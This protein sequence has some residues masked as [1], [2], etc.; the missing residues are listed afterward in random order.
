MRRT[1]ITCTVST[2]TAS[3]APLLALF[4]NSQVIVTY[5][6]CSNSGT[7]M[8]IFELVERA[9]DGSR[10][11][12]AVANS[13]MMAPQVCYR[14]S[15]ASGIPDQLVENV[16]TITGM[17]TDREFLGTTGVNFLV[18]EAIEARFFVMKSSSFRHYGKSGHPI[19]IRC[20]RP[21]WKTFQ[22]WILRVKS[23]Q[24]LQYSTTATKLSTNSNFE[25]I[26]HESTLHN[27]NTF[28][29]HM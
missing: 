4:Q 28:I 3:F 5:A 6:F 2:M 18:V 1:P 23:F 14:N 9:C 7:R 16:H 26:D 15:F 24:L 10:G 11:W 20:R 29:R 13:K 8:K 22:K 19:Q 25:P 17:K 27:I 12:G 21:S